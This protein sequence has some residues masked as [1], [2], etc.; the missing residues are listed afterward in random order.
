M[1]ADRIVVDT[2]PVLIKG[3][4]TINLDTERMDFRLKRSRQEVP[5]GPGAAADQ[6]DGP[7]HRAEAGRRAGRG[8]RTGAGGIGLLRFVRRLAAILPFVE[9]GLAKE[10]RLR[11]CWPTPDGRRAVRASAR[12]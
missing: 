4:G 6:G 1:S 7:D 9:P 5:A 8:R 3:H 2:G 12:R 11:H 10:R